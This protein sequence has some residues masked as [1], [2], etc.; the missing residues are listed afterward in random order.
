MLLII[1]HS[2][3]PLYVMFDMWTI[4]SDCIID[5]TFLLLYKGE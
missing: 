5:K 4:C 2:V 3:N 1:M